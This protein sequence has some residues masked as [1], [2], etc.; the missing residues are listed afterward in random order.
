MP[1]HLATASGKTGK[2][3]QAAA[4]LYAALLGRRERAL[5]RRPP[6]RLRG[7][8]LSIG[9]LSLG[10]T[11]KTPAVILLG[12]ELL[13][14]GYRISVLTRGYGRRSRG[15]QLARD[16]S[17]PA[18]RVGDEPRL[19]ARRLRVPV[20]VGKRRADT[21]AEAE[22]LF[23]TQIHLLD[24]GFQ[25]RRLARDFDL[26]LVHPD[27]LDGRLLPAGRL[28]EPLSALS[29]ASALVCLREPAASSLTPAASLLSDDQ[30]IIARLRRYS[31]SP[32]FFAR[33]RLLSPPPGGMPAVAFCALARPE[34][35]FSAL[36][37]SGWRLAAR[38]VFRDH[39]AYRPRDLAR[40]RYLA[41]R[42]GAILLTTEKDEMNL[43]LAHGLPNL[44]IVPLELEIE[45]LSG[46]MD[47]IL[48]A[49]RARLAA[50]GLADIG[51][52]ASPAMPSAPE[53][54]P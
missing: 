13:A 48:A 4:A 54:R 27:D 39:H 26:V 45:D 47:L 12:S 41:L 28:R 52:S 11:G 15:L 32:L 29:R 40:L 38:L 44:Q 17:E 19:I 3:R 2:L 49:C 46:L 9:N 31:S 51:P 6:A 16:G 43:P 34:S 30:A 36:E 14:R 18:A 5:A 42:H 22:R 21:G 7:A 20:L 23:Q 24:D 33:K 53:V 1:S 10:G 50:A 35:F 8:V 37:Q 25:H